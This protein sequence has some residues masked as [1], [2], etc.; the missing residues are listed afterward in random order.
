MRLRVQA[1]PTEWCELA[2]RRARR[3]I[4]SC[5]GVLRLPRWSSAVERHTPSHGGPSPVNAPK[6]KTFGGSM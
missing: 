4:L 6:G 1:Q 2:D 3:L 5:F